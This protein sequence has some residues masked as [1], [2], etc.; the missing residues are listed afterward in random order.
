M[1][2]SDIVKFI[3]IERDDLTLKDSEKIVDLIIE[4]I[5]MSIANNSRIEIRGFG[6][7]APKKL[8]PK[9]AYIPKGN[10]H[11]SLPERTTIKFK[12]SKLLLDKINKLKTI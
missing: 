4:K 5:T 1:K 6:V 8:K 11:V 3:H 9:I 7:F 2:R 10:R 12:A